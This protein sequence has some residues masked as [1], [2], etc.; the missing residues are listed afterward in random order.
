MKMTLEIPMKNKYILTILIFLTAFEF[1][2]A[3]KSSTDKIKAEKVAEKPKDFGWIVD[4]ETPGSFPAYSLELPIEIYKAVYFSNLSDIRIFD[5]MGIVIPHQL[6]RRKDKT[7]SVEEKQ[8]AP[9]FPIYREGDWQTIEDISGSVHKSRSGTILK[10]KVQSQPAKGRV[11]TSYLIDISHI[12]DITGLELK[13]KSKNNLTIHKVNV[14]GSYT[15]RQWESIA[16]D[17]PLFQMDYEGHEISNSRIENIN[18]KNYRY[19]K[20]STYDTLSNFILLE[21]KAITSTNTVTGNRKM[22][23]LKGNKNSQNTGFIY[24]SKG[25]FSFDYIRLVTIP[26]NTS[27][28]YNLFSKR[29]NE[30]GWSF[31]KKGM[32]YNLNIENNNVRHD[33]MKIAHRNARF[34]KIEIIGNN[35]SSPPQIELGWRP[36]KIIF[37]DSGKRP[38]RLAFGNAHIQFTNGNVDNLV[39]EIMKRERV[40]VHYGIAKPGTIVYIEKGENA[41]TI[42]PKTSKT[43]IILWVIMIFAVLL[44][45]YMAKSLYGQIQKEKND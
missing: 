37:F 30:D 25:L 41:I 5:A 16:N 39:G 2:Y 28:E 42:L 38:Y 26:K 7:V 24:D 14:E 15:L 23:Q 4:V 11:L 45:T 33:D 20:I 13:W 34:W 22:L 10:V 32:V 35:I 36:H 31:V 12:D 19:L 9:I 18:T 29:R 17:S 40:N 43:K 8:V 3:R 1:S 44:L 27:F 6:V 21:A